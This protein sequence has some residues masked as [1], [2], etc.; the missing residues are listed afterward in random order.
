MLRKVLCLAALLLVTLPAAP[1][2][3]QFGGSRRI[4]VTAPGSGRFVA[5]IAIRRGGDTTLTVKLQRPQAAPAGV[6]SASGESGSGVVAAPGPNYNKGGACWDA[7][8]RARVAPLVTLND[9]VQ[10]TPPAV[11]LWVQVSE[12]GRPTSLRMVR[13]SGDDQFDALA[14]GFA[15]SITYNPAQK[16]GRPVAGWVQMRLLPKPR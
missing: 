2:A 11:I 7:P 9:R 14:R 12:D 13:S 15:M 3:Q 5:T 16:D 6:T 10:G 4:E 8:P 1:G